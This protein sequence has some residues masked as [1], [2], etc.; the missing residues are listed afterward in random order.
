[1]KAVTLSNL[2]HSV[3]QEFIRFRIA[4][5]YMMGKIL[6]AISVLLFSLLKSII[7]KKVSKVSLLL[8]SKTDFK[9]LKEKIVSL[10]SNVLLQ[11]IKKVINTIHMYY[12]YAH[13]CVCAC[14]MFKIK[15]FS[16]YINNK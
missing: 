11:L 4:I 9:R 14:E 1:M 12:M 2:R 6:E 7:K 5:K 3:E 15:D 13:V 8:A 16:P 10:F